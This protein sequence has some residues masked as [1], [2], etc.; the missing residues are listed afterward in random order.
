[1]KYYWILQIFAW[2]R[3]S[4]MAIQRSS[5]DESATFKTT[6]P[7]PI[8]FPDTLSPVPH[9]TLNVCPIPRCRHYPFSIGRILRRQH[10]V[11]LYIRIIVNWLQSVC[12]PN[13]DCLVWW[14][15]GE[16]CTWW[17]EGDGWACCRKYLWDINTPSPGAPLYFCT[18]FVLFCHQTSTS[19]WPCSSWCRVSSELVASRCCRRS[20]FRKCLHRDVETGWT[21]R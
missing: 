6:P 21:G 10:R 14:A 19:P 12:T 2:P 4:P 11:I 5:N 15:S 16:C 13:G 18:L 3:T 17:I 9:H 7:W 20:I 8:D 1:M